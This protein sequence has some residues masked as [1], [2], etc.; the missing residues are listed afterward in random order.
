MTEAGWVVVCDWCD[1]RGDCAAAGLPAAIT[2]GKGVI[3][4]LKAEG[5][6]WAWRSVFSTAG[7]K[8]VL[9]DRPG[10][11]LG[12]ASVKA[13]LCAVEGAALVQTSTVSR[14]VNTAVRKGVRAWVRVMRLV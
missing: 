8:A 12:G 13:W 11:V 6:T 2:A 7:G 1:R 5:G 10:C 9:L 3:S 14:L 4:T